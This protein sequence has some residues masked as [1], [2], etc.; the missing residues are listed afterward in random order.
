MEWRAGDGPRPPAGPR[1]VWIAVPPRRSTLAPGRRERALIETV[2]AL[3]AQGE[4]V[5]LS[6]GPSLL[7]MSGQ[8]DPWARVAEPSGIRALTDRVIVDEVPVSEGKRE[9]LLRI[10]GASQPQ[11]K[12]G[13]VVGPARIGLMSAVPLEG[14]A[15]VVASAP[16]IPVR[17]IVSDW[18]P[19]AGG[20]EL[21]PG[22]GRATEA[23]VPVVM[24]S[25]RKR[26]DGTT[27]RMVV[28]GSPQWMRTAIM[29]AVQR[30]GGARDVLVDPG[31][32]ALAVASV[33]WLAGLDARLDA[34]R[35]VED[36][37]RV[38][39]IE[40][41]TRMSWAMAL[42]VALPCALGGM[43]LALRWRRTLR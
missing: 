41:I 42:G 22:A 28:V 33:L 1:T 19:L 43:G 39:A 14:N 17:R 40:P 24:A 12:V 37:E 16:R 25:E 32:R 15:D 5:L 35:T 3:A 38:G 2:T 18:R 21:P 26:S 29:D 36:V 27:S 7:P 11:S 8:D 6:V 23:D 20:G 31:N 4:P 13:A 10:P 34:E 30:L 9:T